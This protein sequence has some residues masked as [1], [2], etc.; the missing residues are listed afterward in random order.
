M[1]LKSAF[2]AVVLLLLTVTVCA[3]QSP[4]GF[5]PFEFFDAFGLVNDALGGPECFYLKGDKDSGDF[6]VITDDIFFNLAYS[7]NEVS[8]IRLVFDVAKDDQR[9]W[10]EIGNLIS[11]T[12]VTMAFISGR[13][14]KDI[15]MDGL[16]Y[17][18]SDMVLNAAPQE[19]CGY[20]FEYSVKDY[21]AGR[22]LGTLWVT[23]KR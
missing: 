10:M 9:T 3:A 20:H 5:S 16:S 23:K 19:Y 4:M 12:F 22:E 15:D 11:E 2:I 18:I 6:I 14:P 21:E 8:E 13:Q 1:K 17:L 7:A